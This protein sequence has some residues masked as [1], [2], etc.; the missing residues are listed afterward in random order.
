MGQPTLQCGVAQGTGQG[1]CTGRGRGQGSPS[2]GMT[3]LLRAPMVEVRTALIIAPMM[4][5]ALV[6]HGAAWQGGHYLGMALY[7]VL[8][9]GAEQLG[10]GLGC[11]WM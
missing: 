6:R 1:T 4:R 10:F 9:Q 11:A 2:E 8:W 7:S 3:S 5:W